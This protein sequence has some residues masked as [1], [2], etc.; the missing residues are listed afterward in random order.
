MLD[1][2]QEEC[3]SWNIKVAEQRLFNQG[4]K[5]VRNIVYAGIETS[6]EDCPSKGFKDCL[7]I[8]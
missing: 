3:K 4:S 1:L 5:Q 8:A 7:M 2:K 6:K